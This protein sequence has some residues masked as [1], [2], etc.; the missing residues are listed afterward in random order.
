MNSVHTYTCSDAP[1]CQFVVV[2]GVVWCAVVCSAREILCS[3]VLHNVDGMSVTLM[4]I[5]FFLPC[6]SVKL[7]ETV[8]HFCDKEL[9]P[10]AGEI[11]QKNEFSKLRV[12]MP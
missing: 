7:R 1:N 3:T 9:A 4:C 12:S 6:M 5:Y 8:R 2:C 11:D 10:F